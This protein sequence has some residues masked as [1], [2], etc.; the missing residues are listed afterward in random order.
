MRSQRSHRNSQ[1]AT[2]SKRRRALVHWFTVFAFLFPAA[3]ILGALLAYPIVFTFA[4]ST[5]DATGSTFIG[6]DNYQKIFSQP[7]TLIAVRNNLIWVLIVPAIITALGLV[8]AVLAQRVPW[9]TAF[10][11]ALFVP[12]VVS[13]LAAGVTFRFLYAA[14]PSLGLA[15]AAIQTIVHLVQPPGLYPGARPSQPDVVHRAEGQADLV[16]NDAV[17]PGGTAAFGMVGIPPFQ[18]PGDAGEA[19]RAQTPPADTIAGTVWLDFSPRGERGVVDEI[20]R[21]LPGVL[22][23][24]V[25]NGEVLGTATTGP[26]GTFNVSDL[27]DGEYQVRLSE[28]S[29][30][31]P[32]GGIPWLGPLLITPAIILGYIWIHTGFAVIITSAGLSGIDENLQSAARVEGANEWQVFRHVT[33]P[34][35]R[36]V[37]MVVLVT[38]IIS[39]LKIFDLVLVIAPESVQY[40]A[41]VLA[42]EMW[43]ASFG[44]AR[45]FGLGSALAALLFLMI[46]PAML[47]NLRRF[48]LEGS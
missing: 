15:N 35:L 4:R 44:G 25:R 18:L 7:R 37:L 20:E 26:D 36:P 46:I 27:P 38:T 23:E 12:L 19:A 8:L 40:N 22:V 47:F 34:L 16:L 29:F 17:T 9:A 33:V 45:D 14:D 43:R 24:V 28:R 42:L 2:S 21:G 30:R 41:N 31:V 10:R 5:F 13:G 11:M 6:L 3:L 1:R 39:V 32:W 48:R